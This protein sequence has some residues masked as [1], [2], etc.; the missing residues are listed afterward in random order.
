MFLPSNGR[1]GLTGD[2]WTGLILNEDPRMYA[3]REE[4]IQRAWKF[5]E[6]AE[7]TTSRFNA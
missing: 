6:G 4:E 3:E 1:I 2:Q 7:T 5:I